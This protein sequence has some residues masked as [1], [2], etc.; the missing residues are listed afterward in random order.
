MLIQITSAL[1]DQYSVLVIHVVS[2]RHWAR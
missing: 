2:F 1:A